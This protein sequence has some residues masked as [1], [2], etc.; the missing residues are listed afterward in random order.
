MKRLSIIVSLILPLSISGC[1]L[2][3]GG[4]EQTTTQPSPTPQASPTPNQNFPGQTQSSTQGS[5]NLP[6]LIPSTEE[7]QVQIATGKQD[8]FAIVPVKPVVKEVS[9]TK[10]QD[11]GKPPTSGKPP[12]PKQPPEGKP[13]APKQPPEGNA[14]ETPPVVSSR[15]LPQELLKPQLEP[16]EARA[17]VV[18]GIVNLTDQPVAILKAANEKV[19]RSVTVG[20]GLSN[21]IFV[22]QITG[23]SV[24]LEQYGIEVIRS[25]GQLPEK[26]VSEVSSNIPGEDSPLAAPVNGVVLLNASLEPQDNPDV[27]KGT[28]CNDTDK[29]IKVVALDIQFEDK[30]SQEIINGAKIKLPNTYYLGPGKRAKFEA[31]LGVDEEGKKT[32]SGNLTGKTADEVKIVLKGWS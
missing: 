5:T 22:K 29:E 18:M 2:F 6:G 25:I 8:P 10:T 15:C 1:S 20:S 24:I 27:L 12:A 7:K 21:G 16:N 32:Q 14:P 31:N 11:A 26:P 9:D 30:A 19:V 4:E 23:N 13:P 28:L 17:T 3:F